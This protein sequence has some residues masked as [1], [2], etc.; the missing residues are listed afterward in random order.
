MK[1]VNTVVI[2]IAGAGTRL[3]PATYATPKE[4]LRLVDKPIIYYLLAEAYHA[5]IKRVLCITHVDNPQTKQFFESGKAKPLLDNFPGLS[6]EFIET[7][8]RRGDGQ[9]FLLA[10][11]HLSKDEPF[12]ATMGDLI[13]RLGESLLDELVNS[14]G[15][16]N[17]P[18]I[19]VEK[20]PIEK[21]G[22]Y[23]VIDPSEVIGRTYAVRGIIEKPK[24]EVAPSNMAMTGKYV[25]TPAIFDY[26]KALRA[27]GGEG[28]IKLANALNAYA[29]EHKLNAYACE[30]VH[31]DT[32]TKIDLFKAEVA[33][34]LSDPE[35]GDKARDFLNG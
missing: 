18:V 10:E 31:F 32:G 14:F 23:G 15:Q 24:P 26:L 9:A 35:L 3:R 34:T 16:T 21:T 11:A 20:I 5:G 8:E 7:S 27:E 19:S 12:A 33:F 13:P 1:N 22:Q 25:L 4:M 28:E 17:T 6:V 2:P 29:K 30:S